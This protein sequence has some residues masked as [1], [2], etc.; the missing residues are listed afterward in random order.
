MVLVDAVA[1]CES[2]NLQFFLEKGAARTAD[3][4]QAIAKLCLELVHDKDQLA[5][6]ANA[7]CLLSQRN[8]AE[9]ICQYMAK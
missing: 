8:G 3:T 1:G 2:G 7:F 9:L 4:P 6:M 5:Q